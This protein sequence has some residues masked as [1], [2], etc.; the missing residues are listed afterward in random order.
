MKGKNKNGMIKKKTGKETKDMKRSSSIG[1]KLIVGFLVPVVFVI[2]LGIIS[3]TKASIGII[4]KHEEASMQTLD[5]TTQYIEFGLSSV[6]SAAIEFQFDDMT[7]KYFLNYTG[8][9][10]LEIQTINTTLF[11]KMHSKKVSDIFIQDIHILSDIVNPISSSGVKAEESYSALMNSEE[12]KK[13]M[14]T[15]Q[16]SGWFG[17]CDAVD[18]LFKVNK[19]R[20]AMRFIRKFATSNSAIVIDVNA[21]TIASILD[22]LDFGD[23][24]Y[25]AIVTADGRE[26]QADES[27]TEIIFADEDFYLEKLDSVEDSGS[28]YINYNGKEYMFMHSKIGETGAIIC[29]LMPKSVITAQAEDIKNITIIIVVIACIVALGLGAIITLG[30]S[31]E[32]ANTIKNL[33]LVASGDLTVKFRTRR[34]DEFLILAK[35]IQEMTDSMKELINKTK[36]LSDTVSESSVQVTS[37]AN[38]F[39]KATREISVA[40]DEIEQGVNQQA[41][42]SENCLHQMDQ[43]SQRIENV[44]KNTY[45]METIAQDTKSAVTSGT[46]KMKELETK[47]ESTNTIINQVVEEIAALE[48]KSVTIGNIVSVINDIAEQT[49]LLSLNASIEAARAGEA[50]RGFSVVADEIRKLA[51][52]STNSVAQIHGIISEIQASVQTSVQHV[53]AAGEG[54]RQQKDAVDDTEKTFGDINCR[55]EQLVENI[56]TITESISDIEE[57]RMNTLLAIESISAVSEENAASS[58][59]VNETSKEQLQQVEMLDS[60]AKALDINAKEL[61]DAVQ[62]FRVK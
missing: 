19:D 31:K 11:N 41:S 21:E 27:I 2:A 61:V 25:V 39:T 5:L 44:S 34:K 52:Q 3:Y 50:G 36:N 32:I 18:E 13:I 57:A 16:K 9:E 29:A 51:D 38:T 26:I 37:S 10:K 49:N 1:F 15:T 23:G 60:A 22:S 58:T 30:I 20:Y 59:A 47:T 33:K 28:E 45:E 53:R 4:S 48:K 8:V 35:N 24:S 46:D 7:T 12:G 56:K 55:V 40:I 43:L 14:E 54:M 42:D 17:F 6:E 62:Q